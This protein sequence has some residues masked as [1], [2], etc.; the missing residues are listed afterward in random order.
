MKIVE[1]TFSKQIKVGLPN[2]SNITVGHSI[3][4]EVKEGEKIDRN[5]AWDV[6]NQQLSIQ[7]GTID[8]SWIKT[9]EYQNFFKTVI[10]TNK[11]VKK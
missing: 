6:V 5:K 2:F 9:R 7:T 4:V 1:E 10:T 11:E 3:T 8:A